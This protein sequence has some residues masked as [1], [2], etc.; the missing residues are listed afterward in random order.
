MQAGS[1][2]IGNNGGGVALQSSAK[3]DMEGGEISGNFGQDNGAAVNSGTCLFTMTGGII[4]NNSGTTA[5][6]YGSNF[7]IKGG[8]IKDNTGIDIAV[9]SYSGT[10]ILGENIDIGV[11]RLIANSNMNKVTIKLASDFSLASGAA[12]ISLDLYGNIILSTAEGYWTS[13]SVA[14]LA[15]DQPS[16]STLPVTNFTLGNFIGSNGTEAITSHHID[17]TSGNLVANP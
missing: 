16:A 11:I 10:I 12:P 17:A 4:T 13:S 3:F 1:K 5:G 14:V 9:S 15:W 8:V 7:N 2:I 6:L